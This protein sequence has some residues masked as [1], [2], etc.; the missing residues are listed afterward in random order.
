MS[1]G[2]VADRTVGLGRVG[3]LVA[4][5][6]LSRRLEDGEHGEALRGFLLARETFIEGARIDMGRLATRLGVDRTSLFRWVGNRDAL[7]SEVLWSLAVPTL[8]QADAATRG[9][10]GA[11]RV[12]AV[13]THVVGDLITA[14]YFRGF[15]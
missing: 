5:S 1:K 11:P 8:E 10:R 14:S 3:T 2:D 7:L 9:T 15:L 4:P 6:W 12:A 13:L